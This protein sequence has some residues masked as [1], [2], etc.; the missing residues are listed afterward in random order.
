MRGLLFDPP[1]V[2]SIAVAGETAAFPVHRIFCVARNYAAHAAEMDREAPFYFTK[3]AEAVIASG[4]SIPYPPG[5]FMSIVRR[6]PLS[7]R[8]LRTG[9]ST[10]NHDWKASREAR[11]GGALQYREQRRFRTLK[12]LV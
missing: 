2:Q 5:A 7:L 3:S 11:P 12:C 4:A 6:F 10:L 8:R 1:E 9:K